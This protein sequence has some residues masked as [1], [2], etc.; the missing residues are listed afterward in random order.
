MY[1][2]L[3]PCW[4][5][6]MLIL[7]SLTPI[8]CQRRIQR[9]GDLNGNAAGTTGRIPS[10]QQRKSE[11]QFHKRVRKKMR[12]NPELFSR[13]PLGPAQTI[14]PPVK[15]QCGQTILK[16]RIITT[17]VIL[18]HPLMAKYG[19]T[20]TMTQF[21]ES[22]KVTA[23][24]FKKLDLLVSSKTR[25]IER[26][27]EHARKVMTSLPL[28]YEEWPAVV[29]GTCPAHYTTMPHRAEE[30]GVTYAHKQVWWDWT[31][32]VKQHY[33]N[34]K[35]G[36]AKRSRCQFDNKNANNHINLR[37]HHILVMFEDD[38][39]TLSPNTASIGISLIRELDNMDTETPTIL[40]LGWCYGGHRALPMCGHAYAIN[41][42]AGEILNREIDLCGTALDGQFQLL[43]R[44]KMIK[45]KKIHHDSYNGTMSP[46]LQINGPPGSGTNPPK[47]HVADGGDTSSRGDKDRNSDQKG[48][49]SGSAEGFYR[50]LFGQATWAGSFNNHA[51]QNTETG[52]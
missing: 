47:G 14:Y 33:L 42:L 35:S 48:Q 23:D 11:E 51:W 52:T 46:L 37:N 8:S 24:Y 26:R 3:R 29:A 4:F 16:D 13:R 45:L 6:A 17:A 10:Y 22:S 2:S 40:F 32:R 50:G 1:I 12:E 38:V 39:D 36:P 43:H 21:S 19:I 27:N 49:E 9:P 15:S 25:L 44:A 7:L 30:R 20:D 28:A 18:T 34:D 5:V 41:Y 31:W